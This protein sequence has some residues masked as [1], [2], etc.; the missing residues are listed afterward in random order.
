VDQRVETDTRRNPHNYRPRP[1]S[2]DSS[3]LPG[4]FVTVFI[5][6]LPCG[7]IPKASA[8]RLKNANIAVI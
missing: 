6:R 3:K 8:T 2:K 4:Y 1:L 5:S 7:A